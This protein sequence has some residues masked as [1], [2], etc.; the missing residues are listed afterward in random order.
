MQLQKELVLEQI[1]LFMLNV[2]YLFQASSAIRNNES[3]VSAALNLFMGFSALAPC[4]L[5]SQKMEKALR[6]NFAT[7][8]PRGY[9]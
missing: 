2:L 9:Y 6:G 8:F 5:L 3:K 1:N 7:L 4:S